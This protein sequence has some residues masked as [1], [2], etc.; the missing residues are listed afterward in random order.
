MLGV[1]SNNR[2]PTIHEKEAKLLSFSPSAKK[3][4]FCLT[5]PS[6]S[7]ITE[8][9]LHPKRSWDGD[10]RLKITDRDNIVEMEGIVPEITNPIDLMVNGGIVRCEVIDIEVS[11]LTVYYLK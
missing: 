7:I 9:V 8:V 3:S 1:K 6:G 2:Q 5:L 10:A 11:K 4:D